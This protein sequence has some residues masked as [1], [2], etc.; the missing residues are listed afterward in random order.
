MTFYYVFGFIILVVLFVRNKTKKRV[1]S[2][3]KKQIEAL[4]TSDD[5]LTVVQV[6]MQLTERT[7]GRKCISDVRI[8]KLLKEMVDASIL[9][10]TDVSSLVFNASGS[11]DIKKSHIDLQS[12]PFHKHMR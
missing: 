7:A 1:D 5:D 9:T 6:S 12:S 3:L 2:L 11:S 8:I 4:F 10:R